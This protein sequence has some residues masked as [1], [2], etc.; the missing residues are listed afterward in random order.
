MAVILQF[1]PR[2]RA[3]QVIEQPQAPISEYEGAFLDAA[4]EAALRAVDVV[5]S[6]T[7]NVRGFISGET[8]L[9]STFKVGREVY[10]VVVELQPL[11]EPPRTA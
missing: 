3:P 10:R 2:E 8:K 5:N 6:G 7:E 9:S 4:R 1:K 11:N